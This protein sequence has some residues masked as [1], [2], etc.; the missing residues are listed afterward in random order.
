MIGANV[1][2]A[3]CAYF[4]PPPPNYRGN[5]SRGQCRRYAPVLEIV[6]DSPARSIWPL[7]SSDQWC[8]D[9]AVYEERAA[10]E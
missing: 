9:H 3:T 2:C 6:T 10:A 5:R 4:M 7:V 8:G 1:S